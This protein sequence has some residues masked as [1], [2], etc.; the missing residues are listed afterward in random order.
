MFKNVLFSNSTLSHTNT[1]SAWDGS[2][3]P[4]A[5]NFFFGTKGEDTL[6]CVSFGDRTTNATRDTP[7]LSNCL[8]VFNFGDNTIQRSSETEVFGGENT[9]STVKKSIIVGDKNMLYGQSGGRINDSYGTIGRVN[10]FG[11]ENKLYTSPDTSV[12]RLMLRG[13]YNEIYTGCYDMSM[14]GNSNKV[15]V[16]APVTTNVGTIAALNQAINASVL[17]RIHT[18]AIMPLPGIKETMVAGET[19]Y[20]G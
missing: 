16:N 14:F 8:R 3:Q 20:S 4:T 9:L 10:I 1:S 19:M 17:S 18:T 13:N 5:E 11:S 2:L 7:I 6:A 15:G 12:E